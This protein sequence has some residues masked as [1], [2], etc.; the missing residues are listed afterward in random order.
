MD[1]DGNGSVDEV[2]FGRE[3]ARPPRRQFG[4]GGPTGLITILAVVGLTAAI[5]V[6]EAR[7]HNGGHGPPPPPVQIAGSELVGFRLRGAS[8]ANVDV[9]YLSRP[10][11]QPKMSISVEAGDLKRG[12]RYL[13]TAGECRGGTPR[14]LARATGTPDSERFLLLTLNGLPGTQRSVVWVRVTNGYGAQLGG[15]RSPFSATGT[16]VQIAPGKPDCPLA[17]RGSSPASCSALP[18]H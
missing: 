15:V 3:R 9:L 4:R 8:D 14:V 11:R 10:G 6:M 2:S 18:A 12:L 13:V 7:R 1:D 16:G 17:W 5:V